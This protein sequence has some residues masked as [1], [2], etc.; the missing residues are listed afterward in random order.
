M[1]LYSQEV[2]SAE[3]DEQIFTIEYKICYSKNI[4]NIL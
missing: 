4:C 3:A 2:Q 1:V